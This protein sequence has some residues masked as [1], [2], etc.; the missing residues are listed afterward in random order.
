MGGSDVYYLCPLYCPDLRRLG[1]FPWE[2]FLRFD[3]FFL[4]RPGVQFGR[5]RRLVMNLGTKPSP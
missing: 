2:F 5:R 1:H 3:S 4:D